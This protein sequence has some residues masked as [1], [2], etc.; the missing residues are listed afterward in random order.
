MSLGETSREGGKG[1]RGG[2]RGGEERGV[3]LSLEYKKKNSHIVSI[4]IRSALSGRGRGAV[5]LFLDL[6]DSAGS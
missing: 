6:G 4:Q 5:I 2:G 1:G 3:L